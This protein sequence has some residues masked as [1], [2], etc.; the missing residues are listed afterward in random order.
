MTGQNPKHSQAGEFAGLVVALEA[1]ADDVEPEPLRGRLSHVLAG[2]PLERVDV[3]VVIVD[4]ARMA[5]LHERFS[6]IPGTTDV[7]TFDLSDAPAPAA[8]DPLQTRAVEGEIYICVD[9][10]RRR[11]ADLGHATEL[12]LLLYAVHGVLHLMGYDDHDEAD[13]QRMHALEDQLLSAAGIGAVFH[14]DGG[15]IQ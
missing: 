11:G 9:E 1:E 8:A 12:E 13:Y 15:N 14:R 5:E 3:N 7:L 10:A 2:L 6:G 4:D